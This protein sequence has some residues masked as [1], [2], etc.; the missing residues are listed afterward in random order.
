MPRTGLPDASKAKVAAPGLSVKV[1]VQLTMA[2]WLA[3]G[4][5]ASAA[6]YHGAAFDTTLLSLSVSMAPT[7]TVAAAGL[8]ANRRDWPL[9]RASSRAKRRASATSPAA[10]SAPNPATGWAEGRA[11]AAA[12]ARIASTSISSISV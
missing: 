3:A 7:V 9:R 2:I 10:A 8:Q 12:M 5:V 1:K 4:I 11:T 6:E